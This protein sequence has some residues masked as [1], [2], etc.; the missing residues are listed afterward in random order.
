[1]P[2]PRSLALGTAIAIAACGDPDD[3]G[4][5]SPGCSLAAG[6]T[7]PFADT[8]HVSAEPAPYDSLDDGRVYLLRGIPG[9]FDSYGVYLVCNPESLAAAPEGRALLT[10]RV[11]QAT[12][13]EIGYRPDFCCDEAHFRFEIDSVDAL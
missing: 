1:M 4:F 13:D 2:T 10:G 3:S 5:V 7:A 11:Q 12:R 6:P 8:F 9:T